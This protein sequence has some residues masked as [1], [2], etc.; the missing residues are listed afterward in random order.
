M[1]DLVCFIENPGERVM[2][3]IAKGADR[4]R[5]KRIAVWAPKS[6]SVV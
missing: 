6:T 2:R 4:G 5:L 1:I 3:R